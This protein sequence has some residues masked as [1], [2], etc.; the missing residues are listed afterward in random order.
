MFPSPV[1][2]T[3]ALARVLAL[4]SLMTSA[5]PAPGEAQRLNIRGYTREDGLPQAQVYAVHQ[6]PRGYVWVGT[7]GG[8]AR[9]DGREFHR[10]TSEDGLTSNSVILVEDAS[11]GGLLVVTTDGVCWIGEGPVRC[12]TTED[13]LVPGQYRAAMAEGGGQVW[14][15]SDL[16]VSRIRDGVVVRSYGV[17]DGLE[18]WVTSLARDD[19]G[20]LWAGTTAGLT[21]LDPASDRWIA[22]P[23][24]GRHPAVHAL[25]LHPLGMLV[26]SSMGLHRA[27]GQRFERIPLGE[28]AEIRAVDVGP[29]GTIWAA[30]LSGLYRVLDEGVTAYTAEHGLPVQDLWD[31]EVD[32]EGNVWMGSAEGLAK[33]VPGPFELFTPDQGLPHP[34]VRAVTEDAR[35]RVWF[36]TRDG[37]A[38]WDGG[39]M[40]AVPLAG[41]IPD[42]KVW[43]LAPD[44]GGGLLVGTSVGL[45][46]LSDAG[47]LRLFGTVDGLPNDGVM[48]LLPD[49]EG[50]VWIG[51]R[52]GVAR[53]R[54][55]AVRPA[56]IRGVGTAFVIS[57]A[58]DATG[59]LWLG[60]ERDGV[61]VVQGDSAVA[62]GA[63][64]G[65]SDQT[66]WAL[67]SD[68]EGGMW[69]GTNGDGARWVDADGGITTFT[70]REGLGDDFVWQVLR[71]SQDAI[72]IFTGYG[73]SRLSGG[74]MAYF[75]PGDGL[76]DLEGSTAAA[77]ESSSGELWFGV[78][79][80]VYRYRRALDRE[81]VPLPVVLVEGVRAGGVPLEHPYNLPPRAGTAVFRF[82]VPSYRDEGGIRFRYR[83]AER[84]EAWSEPSRDASVTLAGLAP[85]YHVLEVVAE[86]EM[87][88]RSHAVTQVPFHVQAA[89]WETLT[90]RFAVVLA[91]ALAV[92]GLIEFRSR[93]AEAERRRLEEL[94]DRRTSE[95]REQSRRLQAEIQEKEEAERA[96]RRMQAQLWEAQKMEAVGRLAGGVAHDFNNLLTTVMGNADLLAGEVAP[97]SELGRGLEEIQVSARRGAELVSQLLAF[98][99]RQVVSH[100]RIDA[101]DAVREALR[102]INPL[103]SARSRLVT[104]LPAHPLWIVG[105][106]HQVGQVVVNLA[107]NALDAMPAGGPLSVGVHACVGP[108]SE[109]SV[110]Q[111]SIPE[112]DYVCIKVVDTGVGMAPELL[113]KAFEP[114][115]TTK[116]V[117]EGSGLGL[118]G[119][120]GIVQELGGYIQVF[121][122]P[123]RGTEVR[124]LLPDGAEGRE[125]GSESSNT[126]G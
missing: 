6:D 58:L 39:R 81:G 19:A 90:F 108:P 77:L 16:G 87:G 97:D 49:G 114:F 44:P 91:L 113:A 34:F 35:G 48:S 30:K 54:N 107:M 63:A 83:I 2:R 7:N 8:L 14:V 69:V 95:I 88:V 105:D 92:L 123:G 61:L 31:L 56:G 4:S 124:V 109:L 118:S 104:E 75:G 40:V 22:V 51:T 78:G 5:L 111:E 25:R 120:Y 71:D 29:D 117:G 11:P 84:G 85:G 20:V 60:L 33:M 55:G 121:S 73:L 86:T 3:R 41:R 102:L 122:E 38:Y 115:F 28:P 62:M 9:Y 96:Q 13:G 53:W 110:F 106:A 57:M 82:S 68:G 24:E 59:R 66:V 94:V 80:G 46:H 37:L 21:R 17:D 126:K 47:T 70:H 67:A 74:A 119:V 43:A 125:E 103:V 65:L 72:W 64:Q 116:N 36:G 89:F 42:T 101:V 32:R 98:S 10:T 27:R 112:G 99:R 23:L 1:A 76:S 15:G 93:R 45:A 100:R 52:G 50:G 79:T 26:G 18:G 12:L